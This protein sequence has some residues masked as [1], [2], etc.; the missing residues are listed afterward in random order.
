MP[1]PTTICEQNENLE[2]S[3]ATMTTGEATAGL[4]QCFNEASVIDDSITVLLHTV[5]PPDASM[6]P[7]GISSQGCHLVVCIA[8]NK[9]ISK[10]NKQ[11]YLPAS[12]S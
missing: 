11:K 12:T 10:T 6:V 9:Y 1:S 4:S 3:M 7:A 8:G 5:S 2:S